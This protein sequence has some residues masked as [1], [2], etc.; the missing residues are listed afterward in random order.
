MV[1]NNRKI[2]EAI[3][4]FEKEGK[5]LAQ[6]IMVEIH[7]YYMKKDCSKFFYFRKY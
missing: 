5:V 3:T 4:N 2:N 1:V 7:L 6:T